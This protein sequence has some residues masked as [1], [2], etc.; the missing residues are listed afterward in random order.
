MSKYS[1]ELNCLS[2]LLHTGTFR[3]FLELFFIPVWC[4]SSSE[5]NVLTVHESNL[6]GNLY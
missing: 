1:R 6:K 2:R 5:F 4:H 3:I